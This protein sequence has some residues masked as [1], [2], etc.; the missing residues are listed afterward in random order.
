M[1]DKSTLRPDF[2]DIGNT[3]IILLEELLPVA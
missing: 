1:L 2:E 3:P